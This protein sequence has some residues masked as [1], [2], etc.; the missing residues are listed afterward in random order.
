MP[1]ESDVTKFIRGF[2]EQHPE[3]IASQK[4]SRAIWWDK[5]PQQRTPPVPA[6]HSPKTGGAEYTFRPLSEPQE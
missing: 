5:P 1:Y 4:K 6:Q 3:E 2:L